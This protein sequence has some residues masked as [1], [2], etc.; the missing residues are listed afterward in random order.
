MNLENKVRLLIVEDE[1]IVAIDLKKTL[2]K[3]G[4][5]VI[6]CVRRGED[7]VEIAY[8]EKPDLILMDIMLEGELTGIDAAEIIK[9]TI[10][11]PIVYLTAYADNDTIKKAKVTEPAGYLLK[12]FEDRRLLSTIETAL[13]NFKVESKLKESEERYRKLVEESPLA[14]AI[15]GERKIIYANPSA[16]SV[17]GAKG[18]SDFLKK[19]IFDF[20]PIQYRKNFKSKLKSLLL[21]KEKIEISNEKLIKFNGDVIDVEFTAVPIKYQNKFAVQI[22]IRDITENKVKELIQQATLKILQSS[23]VTE[24]LRDMLQIIFNSLE[25]LVEIRNFSLSLYNE[26]KNIIEFPFYKDEVRPMPKPRKPSKG[27]TEYVLKNGEPVFLKDHN[28]K[29][30]IDLEEID[31]IDHIPNVWLG[32]PLQIKEKNI[33]VLIIKDYNSPSRINEREREILEYLSFPISRAIEKKIDEAEKEKITKELKALNATKDKFFSIISHDLRS[34]FNSILGFAEILKEDLPT[35]TKKELNFYIDSLYESTKHTYNILNNLLEFSSFKTGNFPYDPQKLN[36]YS[37]VERV[38]EV[39]S[40]NLHKKEIQ[41]FNKTHVTHF[42]KADEDMIFSAVQNLLSNAVKFSHSGGKVIVSSE[43]ENGTILISIQD[44]GIG[45]DENLLSKLFKLEEKVSRRGTND[46]A[47][48]GLG[49]IIIKEFIEKHG[50]NIKVE[51]QPNKGSKFIFTL[52]SA[53]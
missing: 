25:E 33:G 36:L 10:D 1:N 38:C 30:L 16:V 32:V 29:R 52:P 8:T 27:L 37:L 2:S 43:Q 23:N 41:F 6:A 14:T 31:R 7:A 11:I 42:I 13:Y 4:F 47:G 21:N 48:T 20:I 51:S 40:G 46:E 50:G 28:I 45:M 12:P 49:L 17:F 3:L 39:I 5:D 44:E 19:P 53:K 15:I 22:I 26:D 9:R 35:L 24:N 18:E 34:P